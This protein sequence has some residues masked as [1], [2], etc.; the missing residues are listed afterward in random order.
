MVSSGCSRRETLN[1][2]IADYIKS[3]SDYIN[4]VDFYEI[5]K[6][7][8]DNEDV[9]P[10]FRL[11]RQKT[12]KYYYTFCSPEA[13]QKIAYYLIIRCHNKYDLKE[14]LFDIGLHHISTKFAQINGRQIGRASCRER[15]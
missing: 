5:L 2:T 12:N 1:L 9:V 8:V 3:V 10:T 4:Q 15:V 11:K 13:S 6:F 14:P 7:L